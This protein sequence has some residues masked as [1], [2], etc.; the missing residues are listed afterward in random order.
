MTKQSETGERCVDCGRGVE[1]Q[2]HR[3]AL[4][5]RL[6]PDSDFCGWCAKPVTARAEAFTLAG[7]V[8]LARNAA[9]TPA[10]TARAITG[11]E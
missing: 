11:A 10:S 8:A 1:M 3:D 4:G 9:R 5:P 7:Y 6:L 2:R